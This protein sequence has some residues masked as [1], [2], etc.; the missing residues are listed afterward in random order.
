MQLKQQMQLK[1]KVIAKDLTQHW[2]DK[3]MKSIAQNGAP[4][5][6]SLS[7]SERDPF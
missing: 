2:N 6:I 7:E 1:Q 5:L 4:K 3:F